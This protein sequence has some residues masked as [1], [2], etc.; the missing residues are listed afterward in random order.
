M[1]FFGLS[2]MP[3]RYGPCSNLRIMARKLS[4]SLWVS[5]PLP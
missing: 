2:K 5:L 3:E 1:H 4:L